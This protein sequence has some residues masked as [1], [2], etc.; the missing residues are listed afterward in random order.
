MA[1]VDG[2]DVITI[3]K[4]YK[5]TPT[6]DP[7]HRLS[8]DRQ[9]RFRTELETILANANAYNSTG[10][11]RHAFEPLIKWAKE[12]LETCDKDLEARQADLEIAERA[13]S[14]ERRQQEIETVLLGPNQSLEALNHL[15]MACELATEQEEG[16]SEDEEG[17][18]SPALHQAEG[19]DQQQQ[20]AAAA[21]AGPS[22]LKSNGGVH[23]R[24]ARQRNSLGEGSDAK[25][26]R[27]SVVPAAAVVVANK[28]AADASRYRRHKSKV[29]IRPNKVVYLPTT[30]MEDNFD[31]ASL[32]VNCE[33]LVETNGEELPG[34]HMVTIKA[35]PRQ[36]LSTMYCMTNVLSFQQQFLNWQILNWTRVDSQHIK[37]H[38]QGPAKEMGKNGG[39]GDPDDAPS[40]MTSHHHQSNPKQAKR[41]SFELNPS[42]HEMLATLRPCQGN[43]NSGMAALG[44]NTAGGFINGIDEVDK[45]DM[46]GERR[47]RNADNQDEESGGPLQ[48][49]QQ[50]RGKDSGTGQK[51][52]LPQNPLMGGGRKKQ[53]QSL[54]QEGGVSAPVTVKGSGSSSPSYQGG[55]KG[56]GG[57]GGRR[58]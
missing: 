36:G 31:P 48:E 14:E 10:H 5:G 17:E 55:L 25:P 58:G 2:V 8:K 12:L 13:L 41:K 11:G 16:Y 32:P 44:S 54:G 46:C 57:E 1:G 39:V 56:S 51:L 27:L 33:M 19:Q 24:S 37:I 30:F 42:N 35:V 28:A 50:H 26:K 29:F 45:D 22:S 49:Q 3:S 9:E 7:P 18:G 52:G 53:H 4:D 23:S 34:R 20:Q 40:E 6:T 43:V 38:L 21:A 15:V 47:R